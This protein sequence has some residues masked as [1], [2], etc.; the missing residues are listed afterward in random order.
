M[1]LT[2]TDTNDRFLLDGRPFFHLT[3]TIWAR[4]T[5][6]LMDLETRTWTVPTVRA[7][8]TSHLEL[9]IVNRDSLFIA[10]R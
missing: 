1:P 4:Y 5:C 8:E 7:G 10:Q 3:D 6:R 9:S 2:I